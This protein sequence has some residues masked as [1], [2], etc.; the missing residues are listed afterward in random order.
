MASERYLRALRFPVLTR[1]YDPVVRRTTRE[2]FS[3]SQ[4]RL[5]TIIRTLAL[6][7]ACRPTRMERL[8]RR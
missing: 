2:G 1:V 8:T 5:R 4:G 6:Y 3:K 7:R